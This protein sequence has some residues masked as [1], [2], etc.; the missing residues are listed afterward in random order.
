MDMETTCKIQFDKTI[1]PLYEKLSREISTNAW[2]YFWSSVRIKKSFDIY[3]VDEIIQRPQLI[4]THVASRKTMVS[5][6]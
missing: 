6:R 4:L 3:I 2:T 5:R 1:W